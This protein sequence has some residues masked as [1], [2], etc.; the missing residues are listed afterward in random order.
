MNAIETPQPGQM[1]RVAA[2]WD[3]LAEVAEVYELNGET[4][5]AVIDEDGEQHDIAAE[6][7]R[8]A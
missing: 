7:A 6:D 3:T 1:V 8:L 5:L 2:L 4:M